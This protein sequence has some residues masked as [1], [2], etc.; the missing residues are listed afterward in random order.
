MAKY[1]KGKMAVFICDRSGRKYPMRMATREPG[2]GFLVHRQESDGLFNVVDHP[3]NFPSKHMQDRVALKWSNPGRNEVANDET[4]LETE[5]GQAL[6]FE[7]A[8][9]EGDTPIYAQVSAGIGGV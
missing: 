6:I 9:M 3:Q 2:T 8:G 1:A 4:F 5:D 7:G